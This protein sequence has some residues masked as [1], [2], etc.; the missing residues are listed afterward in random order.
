MAAQVVNEPKS[1]AVKIARQKSA[2][3]TVIT[4]AEVQGGPRTEK[5]GRI[6][7]VFTTLKNL[8]GSAAG[9]LF[10]RRATSKP[11]PFNT[12]STNK[13]QIIAPKVLSESSSEEDSEDSD[14]GVGHVNI[15]VDE[16]EINEEDLKIKPQASSSNLA[17]PPKFLKSRSQARLQELKA[18]NPRLN[19]QRNDSQFGLHRSDSMAKGAES[20]H[21]GLGVRKLEN[22]GLSSS[23]LA[24]KGDE[25][26]GDPEANVEMEVVEIVAASE[27]F[28]DDSESD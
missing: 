19:L 8:G 18:S 15:V 11:P 27:F 6:G 3:F 16:I 12:N 20:T 21:N 14:E 7:T 13:N 2:D 10:R 22:S 25:S 9:A 28:G 5:R 24:T 1:N 4:K 17:P 26:A 23:S